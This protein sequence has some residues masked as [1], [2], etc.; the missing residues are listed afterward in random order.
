MGGAVDLVYRRRGDFVP[1]NR[2]FNGC[3]DHGYN[4]EVDKRVEFTKNG[5]SDGTAKREVSMMRIKE[6]KR[7]EWG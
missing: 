1:L 5:E 4:D 6:W 3:D 7:P 2:Q